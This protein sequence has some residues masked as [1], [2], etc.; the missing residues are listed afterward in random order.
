MKQSLCFPAIWVCKQ[1]DNLGKIFSWIDQSH[2]SQ[3]GVAHWLCKYDICSFCNSM[4]EYSNTVTTNPATTLPV[5]LG[6]NIADVAEMNMV[7]SLPKVKYSHGMESQESS[8]QNIDGSSVNSITLLH[9][10][11]PPWRFARQATTQR[12]RRPWVRF[13][14]GEQFLKNNTG[15]PQLITSWSIMIHYD[16][17]FLHVTTVTRSKVRTS[18]PAKLSGTPWS[19]KKNR[20]TESWICDNIFQA[21]CRFGKQSDP[22]DCHWFLGQPIH[23]NQDTSV[24]AEPS[25][26]PSGGRHFVNVSFQFERQELGAKKNLSNVY[27][28]N[29]CVCI[30]IIIHPT[31]LR[32]KPSYTPARRAAP[33]P[34]CSSG[35]CHISTMEAFSV[36]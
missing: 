12:R 35:A 5:D 25:S 18:I 23:T 33:W 20:Q 14:P 29:V 11:S 9:D 6:L 22:K 10:N 24:S 28:C 7:L 27:V 17:W 19:T 2:A 16:P 4:G 8:V 15:W 34:S 21:W 26:P 36:E 3:L 30:Y 31:L 13:G 32:L 1:A